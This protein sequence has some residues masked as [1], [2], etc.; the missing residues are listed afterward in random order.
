MSILVLFATLCMAYAKVCS[1]KEMIYNGNFSQPALFSPWSILGYLPGGA[2]SWKSVPE[3]NGFDLWE[4]GAMGSPTQDASGTP[5]GQ[6]LEINGN[7]QW[8]QISYNFN[9]PCLVGTTQATYSFEYWYNLQCGCDNFEFAI[10]QQ[11]KKILS[12]TYEPKSDGWTSTK[13]NFTFQTCQPLTVVFTSSARDGAGVHIDNVSLKIQECSGV[14][15]VTGGDFE[16]PQ[17]SG[18]WEKVS[19]IPSGEGIWYT[20]SVF[21]LWKE[22]ALGAPIAGTK[23]KAGGQ[24]LEINGESTKAQVGYKFFTPFLLGTA[25]ST[26]SFNYWIRADGKGCECT[27]VNY[28]GYSIEQGGKVLK[29]ASLDSSKSGWVP[30][31]VTVDLEP[32]IPANIYFTTDT[33]KIGGVHIDSVSLTVS[34]H[35]DETADPKDQYDVTDLEIAPVKMS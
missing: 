11:G 27:N 25:E 26:L 16:S 21:V 3:Q 34:E 14:E 30:V 35:R 5:T 31:S 6:H 7:S 33:N 13:G 15:M 1:E 23:S 29:S 4:Q 22:G 2:G 17:I 28:F 24:F 19:T 20:S 12:V 9:T 8:A 10:E 32:T 18:A